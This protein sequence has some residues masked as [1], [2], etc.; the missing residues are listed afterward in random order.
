MTGTHAHGGDPVRV[1][2]VGA[3]GIA[4]THA[5]AVATLGDAIRVVAAVE[6]NQGARTAFAEVA[7]V[8]FV[9][10]TA[11]LLRL[12]E[13]GEIAIDALVVCTPPSVREDVIVPAL[14][15]GLHVL[16]EKPL[17]RT[18]LET[19]PLIEAEASHA[20]LVCAVGYCHRFTP[21]MLEM[22]RLLAE[23]ALGRL[24]RFENVFAFHHPPMGERWFSD[25]VVSGGGS[26]VDTGCHS[27][28][29]FQFLVGS[30]D[31]CG[32][33]ADF[34]WPDR[35]DSS[36]SVLV[37]AGDGAHEGVAGV[38][39]SGWLEPAR[40]QVRLVGTEGSL[41]YDYETPTALE[42]TAP[43]G[44]TDAIDVQPH[45]NRFPDQLAAFAEAVGSGRSASEVGLASFR[46][47]QIVAKAVDSVHTAVRLY[48][49]AA[50]SRLSSHAK[51]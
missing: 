16:V 24:T 23:G 11:D 45:E 49:H 22:K 30:P 26:F 42:R 9:D 41:F 51:G 43:D 27:L 32:A 3:G 29:L 20:G 36:G 40:F 6:P 47:A 34:A 38:I 7:D 18:E 12:R 37:R 10:T 17:A 1:A 28:D 25:A 19:I 35:G 50:M 39:L 44:K 4:K 48:N 2:L 31:V 5:Q 14:K 46:E 8:P 13:S 33:T 21:A 15:A